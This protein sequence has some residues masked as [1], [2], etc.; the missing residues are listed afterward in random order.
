MIRDMIKVVL[1]DL[2]GGAG[3]TK[4]VTAGDVRGD[5]WPPTGWDPF[6][7]CRLVVSTAKGSGEGSRRRLRD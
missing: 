4:A 1:R 3:L 6:P 2:G 5:G 7:V